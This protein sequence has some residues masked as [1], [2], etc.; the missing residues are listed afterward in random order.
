MLRDADLGKK[1]DVPWID[2]LTL[3][4]SFVAAAGGLVAAIFAA[5]SW[6]EIKASAYDGYAATFH[7]ID[8][9]RR[10]I[11]LRL[12]RDPAIAKTIMKRACV[13][14]PKGGVMVENA[15]LRRSAGNYSGP[16]FEDVASTCAT[17]APPVTAGHQTFALLH[18]VLP[19]P[20]ERIEIVLTTK[21]ISGRRPASERLRFQEDFEE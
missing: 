3:A 7:V 1:T 11:E 10:R 20:A 13:A 6:R 17:I 19:A 18:I 4:S 9:N 16:K 15:T 5:L 21:A 12:T 2:I 8:K 14:E